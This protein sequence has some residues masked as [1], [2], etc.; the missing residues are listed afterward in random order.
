MV[1]I[2]IT[3]CNTWMEE[4]EVTGH[5]P[6][7]VAKTALHRRSLKPTLRSLC[8]LVT[9]QNS[10][11]TKIL[12]TITKTNCCMNFISKECEGLTTLRLSQ[13]RWYFISFRFKFRY[14][15][16]KYPLSEFEQKHWMQARRLAGFESR[17]CWTTVTRDLFLF[18]VDSNIFG[19]LPFS[20][21]VV[22]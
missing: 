19:E 20:G 18:T 1:A 3:Q 11:S 22:N 13:L 15:Y 5:T 12:I 4:A 9:A 10:P 7:C 17:Q 6:H 14:L 21:G 8:P 16:I 2:R